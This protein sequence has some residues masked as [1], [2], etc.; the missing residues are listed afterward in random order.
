MEALISDLVITQGAILLV[1]LSTL[2]SNYLYFKN[3]L[4]DLIQLFCEAFEGFCVKG[5]I[6]EEYEICVRFLGKTD[7]LPKEVQEVMKTVIEKTRHHKK[8]IFNI[9]IPYGARDEMATSIKQTAELLKTV[10]DGRFYINFT[11]LIV[12]GSANS[13]SIV[14]SMVYG[15]NNNFLEQRSP[16]NDDVSNILAPDDYEV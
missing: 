14:P 13:L 10:A 9:C 16:E 4:L 2:T 5:A 15:P 8:R 6:V 11:T 1:D 3:L 12:I 7:Q